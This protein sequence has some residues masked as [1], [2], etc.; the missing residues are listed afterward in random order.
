MMACSRVATT[1]CR[2]N[3]SIFN[4]SCEMPD[5]CSTGSIRIASTSDSST[6]TGTG[7]MASPITGE[8]LSMARMRQNGHHTASRNGST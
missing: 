3:G 5:A 8:A 6:R 2:E 1:A 7:T 4:K